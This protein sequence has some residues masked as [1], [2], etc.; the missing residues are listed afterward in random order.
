MNKVTNHDNSE[1]NSSQALV[2]QTSQQ[3]ISSELRDYGRRN[4]DDY[5]DEDG[6]DFWKVMKTLSRWKW[7]IL[8]IVVL[9][10]G[11]TTLLTLKETPLY[12]AATTIEIQ[13][14]E[15]QI[16]ESQSIDPVLVADAEFMA[17]Q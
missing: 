4:Q 10:V 9:G 1:W 2:E 7:L 17:T 15:Q 3:S 12:K 5:F 13:K 11:A 14:Q 8:A 6:F 16:L